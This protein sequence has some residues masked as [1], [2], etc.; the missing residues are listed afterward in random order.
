MCVCV[1]VCVCVCVRACV[2]V[3]VPASKVTLFA[4]KDLTTKHIAS[5]HY[6][7]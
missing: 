3:R 1:W 6:H 7:G 2:R 5:V 4:Q